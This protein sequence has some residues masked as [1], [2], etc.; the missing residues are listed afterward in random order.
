MNEEHLLVQ[1][2]V[3]LNNL[4]LTSAE[5]DRIVKRWHEAIGFIPEDFFDNAPPGFGDTHT[6]AKLQQ[7]AV[8]VVRERP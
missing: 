4:D 2:E 3:I 8:D 7:I 5:V 1:A 6:L